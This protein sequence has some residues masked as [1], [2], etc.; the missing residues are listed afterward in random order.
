MQKLIISLIP[1]TMKALDNV[2]A[3][4]EEQFLVLGQRLQSIYEKAEG[5]TD[6]T[7]ASAEAVQT[8][9]GNRLNQILDVAKKDIA[10]LEVIRETI[11]ENTRIFPMALA[12]LKKL[13][14][15]LEGIDRA[16]R[17]ISTIA[18]EFMVETARIG[19]SDKNFT[20]LS[21][22]IKQL[23]QKT[24]EIS[25]QIKLES[26]GVKESFEGSQTMVTREIGHLAVLAQEA[27]A[28]VEEAMTKIRELAALS[29]AALESATGISKNNQ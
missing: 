20:V 19:N 23:S 4:C 3:A 7:I 21:N 16:A 29:F 2:V 9:D 27:E 25:N 14:L 1:D 12:H 11:Q 24:F 22:E 13:A 8:Q 5:L 18:L 10:G 6:Q 17:Q 26:Q 15:F 28:S